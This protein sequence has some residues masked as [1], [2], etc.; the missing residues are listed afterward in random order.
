MDFPSSSSLFTT[1]GLLYSSFSFGR[2][3]EKCSFTAD[4]QSKQEVSNQAQVRPTQEAP[5]FLKRFPFGWI[6][7]KS[8]MK[9]KIPGKYPYFSQLTSLSCLLSSF[10]GSTVI[11]LGL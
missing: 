5:Q 4:Y 6:S 2:M 11:H 8:A 1:F 9:T 10:T 3:Q 7:F